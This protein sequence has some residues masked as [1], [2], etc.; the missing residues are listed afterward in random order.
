[1]LL[2]LF[3]TSLT[4]IRFGAS[5]RPPAAARTPKWNQRLRPVD[6]L[7]SLGSALRTTW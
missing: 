6:S 7:P 1:M 4:W 5:G 3:T 2:M